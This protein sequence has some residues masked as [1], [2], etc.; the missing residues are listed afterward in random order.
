M[1]FAHLKECPLDYNTPWRPAVVQAPVATRAMLSD[2]VKCRNSY[3]HYD[4]VEKP[5]KPVGVEATIREAVRSGN[6]PSRHEVAQASLCTSGWKEFKTIRESQVKSMRTGVPLQQ[7][8]KMDAALASLLG[9][10][11]VNPASQGSDPWTVPQN[12]AK[13]SGAPGM[14]TFKVIPGTDIQAPPGARNLPGLPRSGSAPLLDE[15]LSPASP[16]V[17][18]RLPGE[19]SAGGTIGQKQFR[20]FESRGSYS[21]KVHDSQGKLKGVYKG[22]FGGQTMWSKEKGDANALGATA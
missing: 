22:H 14:K 19:I 8:N 3:Q 4:P 17:Q 12:F 11:N 1:P 20:Q 9:V 13:Q 7:V 16:S 5:E 15:A 18:F 10:N 2:T 21:P 6:W